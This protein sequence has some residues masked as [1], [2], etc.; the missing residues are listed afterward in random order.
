MHRRPGPQPRPVDQD[1]LIVGGVEASAGT[2][3]FRNAD[4]RHLTA[5]EATALLDAEYLRPIPAGS[6]YLATATSPVPWPPAPAPML[7]PAGIDRW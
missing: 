6:S 5:K 3:K 1:E 7:L 4:S 2:W